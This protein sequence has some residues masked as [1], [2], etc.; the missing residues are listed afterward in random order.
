MKT[1]GPGKRAAVFALSAALHALPVAGLWQ[2]A[3]SAQEV[4]P[5]PDALTVEMV[6]LAPPQ[7]PSERPPGPVQIEAAARKAPPRHVPERV[8]DASVEPLKV[9]PPEE[10]APLEKP[11]DAPPAPATTAPASKPAPPA[12]KAVS[13]PPDWRA[14][15]LTHI[16]QHKRYPA[17]A[18][19]R[20]Q[21]GAAVVCFT[22]DARGKVLSRRL[23]R[24]SGVP[25]LDAEALRVLRAASPLPVPADAGLQEQEIV[26]VLEF[27]IR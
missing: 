2:W 25:S 16:E 18:R 13:A 14:R 22:V 6:R 21:Q 19:I 20:R 3:R 23:V 26:V 8:P 7:P 10:A 5:E 24:S 15:L 12:P 9:P 11:S 17:E 1:M 27:F 4:P